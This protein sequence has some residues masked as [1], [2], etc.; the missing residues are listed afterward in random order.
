MTADRIDN[1]NLSMNDKREYERETRPASSARMHQLN[2][3]FNSESSHPPRAVE[4][5]CANTHLLDNVSHEDYTS[6]AQDIFLL[7]AEVTSC[8]H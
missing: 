6:V 3:L 7:I 1:V 8:K 2:K 4:S 5:S